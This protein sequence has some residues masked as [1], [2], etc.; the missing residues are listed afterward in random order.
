MLLHAVADLLAEEDSLWL[1]GENRAGAKSAGKHLGACFES[2]VKRDAARHCVLYEA[3]GPRVETP[4]SLANYETAWTLE[5]FGRTLNIRSYPGVFAHGGL[6]DGTSLLLSALPNVLDGWTP[7][8]ALDLGCGSGVLGAALLAKCPDLALTQTDTNALA[9]AAAHE[10][11]SANGMSAQTLASDGLASVSG[12]FDLMVSN[13]P[14]HV[15]HRERTDRGAGLFRQ[16]RNFLNPNGQL[17][18]VANRHL[19]WPDTLDAEFGGHEVLAVDNRF[20]VLRASAS[21]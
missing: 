4:F 6:D 11:L 13:P 16:A 18:M 10:T 3:R 1:A 9:L 7:A 2:V 12:R 20:Q 14:F 5:A 8:S 17:V 21:T 15:D 19:P